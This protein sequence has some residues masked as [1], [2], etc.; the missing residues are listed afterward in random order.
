[1]GLEAN[2]VEDAIRATLTV[3]PASEPPEPREELLRRLLE[4]GRARS[5]Y[6]GNGVVAPNALVASLESLC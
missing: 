5:T 3:L 4:R 1:L 2:S 6:L